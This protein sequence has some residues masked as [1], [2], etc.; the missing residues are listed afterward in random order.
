MAP[1]SSR[2][3]F[4]D[5]AAP[6]VDVPIAT[7]RGKGGE[8]ATGRASRLRSYR[9]RAPGSGRAARARRNAAVRGDAPV[10]A[11]T[12]PRP[13]GT[14]PP[15]SACSTSPPRSPTPVPMPD[16]LEPNDD[17]EYVRPDG[18]YDTVDPRPH[19]TAPPRPRPYRPDRPGRG[20]TRR[21]SGLAAATGDH[22]RRD[23]RYQPRPRPLET[24]HHQRLEKVISADR[25]ARGIS[26]GNHRTTDLPQHRSRQ[27]R[28]PRCDSPKGVREATYT[29]R[30]SS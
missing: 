25:L 5:F 27:V 13:G 9:A 4:V 1:F 26:A 15:A 22:G 29:L 17:V 12:S 23:R 7:A 19:K 11:S 10:G 21:L 8:T 14:T 3:R 18:L 20:S 16:P 30:L 2:S 6:G 28:L 24:R